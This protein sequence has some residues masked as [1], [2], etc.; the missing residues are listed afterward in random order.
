[1]SDDFGTRLFLL[2][3]LL[4]AVGTVVALA[5]SIINGQAADEA[6]RRAK[7]KEREKDIEWNRA[8][9][10]E[11]RKRRESDAQVAAAQ[12]E[13]AAAQQTVVIA[14][15]DVERARTEF[16]GGGK[17]LREIDEFLRNGQMLFQRLGRLLTVRVFVVPP[18]GRVCL[19][20]LVSWDRPYP[21]SVQIELCGTS[22]DTEQAYQ[23]TWIRTMELGAVYTFQLYVLDGTN[24][25]DSMA[26]SVQVPSAEQWGRTVE[27]SQ[28]PINDEAALTKHIADYRKLFETFVTKL[29]TREQLKEEAKKRINMSNL[30]QDQ[31][32]YISGLMEGWIAREEDE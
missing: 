6:E 29:I 2:L 8:L 14:K 22:V 9:E 13:A 25:V 23:G 31:E 3:L 20:W 5:A 30:S 18:T 4:V 24:H 17:S 12:R 21:P 27:P 32:K 11:R 1:M 26:L 19:E 16:A 28:L 15:K 7:A 10:N